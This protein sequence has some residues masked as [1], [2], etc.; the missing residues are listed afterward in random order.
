[1]N[2]INLK[3]LHNFQLKLNFYL[4]FKIIILIVINMNDNLDDFLNELYENWIDMVI[5][6]VPLVQNY[7][8]EFRQ[9]TF[10]IYRNR[11]INNYRNN[12][13]EIERNFQARQRNINEPQNSQYLLD[14]FNFIRNTETPSSDRLHNSNINTVNN[15][16]NLINNSPLQNIQRNSFR[17]QQYIEDH[18]EQEE[19][20]ESSIEQPIQQPIEQPIRRSPFYNTQIP[21][22]EENLNISHLVF[23]L[24]G[25]IMNYITEPDFEHVKITISEEDFLNLKNILIT[26]ENIDIYKEKECNICLEQYNLNEKLKALPCNHFFH[27]NCIHDWLCNEKVNC[28]ICRKDIRENN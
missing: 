11:Y 7:N 24:F 10:N 23:D 9:Q 8:Q 26:D 19:P 14:I 1:M 25:N 2:I 15:F 21:I 12:N 4:K 22:Q 6:N 13:A 16:L 28:P 20:N 3:E 18:I 5:D 27:E 17:Q